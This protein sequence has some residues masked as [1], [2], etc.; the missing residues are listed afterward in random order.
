MRR[1]ND[2]WKRGW[3]CDF[4][5]FDVRAPSSALL[6]YAVGW[7]APQQ[8]VDHALLCTTRLAE[9]RVKL[10]LG[11]VGEP[12]PHALEV[13]VSADADAGGIFRSETAAAVRTRR[14]PGALRLELRVA[15]LNLLARALQPTQE[16]PRFRSTAVVGVS[17]LR[18]WTPTLAAG[19][20][21]FLQ[22]REPAQPLGDMPARPPFP[23]NLCVATPKE[24]GGT[25]ACGVARQRTQG[26]RVLA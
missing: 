11:G 6:R 19:A 4:Y 26:A 5:G 22:A 23:P 3:S 25:R 15:E 2:T 16:P 8:P 7:G 1:R 17:A 12:R 21:I 10:R 24:G 14:G 13:A 18:H 9:D 20:E